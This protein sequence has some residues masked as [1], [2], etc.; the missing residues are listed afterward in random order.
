MSSPPAQT[1]RPPPHKRKAPIDD[2]L[3]ATVL[4]R[5]VPT[6]MEVVVTFLEILQ[7]EFEPTYKHSGA[8]L[9]G[10]FS[11]HAKSLQQ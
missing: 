6:E 1:S 2:F 8:Q 3:A 7:A 9:G 10:P 5:L 11:R 4:L